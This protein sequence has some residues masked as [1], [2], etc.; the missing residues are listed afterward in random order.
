MPDPHHDYLELWVIYERPSDYP[1]G[2]VLR[3]HRVMFGAHSGRTWTDPIG[4][5]YETLEAARAGLP[6]GRRNIGRCDGD[7][8]SIKEVWL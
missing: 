1:H 5:S 4:F 7:V 8:P 2:Y 3:R 6:P